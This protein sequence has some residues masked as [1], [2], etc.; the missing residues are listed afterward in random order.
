M[1]KTA[2]APRR[3]NGRGA[4]GPGRPV[5]ERELF[6]PKRALAEARAVIAVPG[7][8]LFLSPEPTASWLR[9]PL[10]SAD[11]AFQL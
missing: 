3:R 11:K 8:F 10:G 2:V 9:I 6:R 5:V 7:R 1:E 4:G